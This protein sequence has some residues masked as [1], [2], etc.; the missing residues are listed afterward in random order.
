MIKHAKDNKVFFYVFLVFVLFLAFKVVLAYLSITVLAFIFGIV[1]QSMFKFFLRIFKNKKAL[2]SSATLLTFLI[3]FFIPLA[4]IVSITVKQSITFYNDLND[5]IEGGELDLDGITP[6][7]NNALDKIPFVDIELSEAKVLSL[8]KENLQPVVNFLI[9]NAT[10][11]GT[12]LFGSIPKFIIFV[13]MLSFLIPNQK[14]LVKQI[15]RLSPLDDEID[16]LL[17]NKFI[18]MSKSMI[19]GSF[20]IALVQGVVS[21]LMLAVVGVPYSIFWTLIITFVSIIPLGA[22]IINF[23]IGVILILFGNV[24]QGILVLVNH[25]LVITNLDNLLRPA[26]VS[27]DAHLHPALTLLGALGG[28]SAFGFWGVIYGPVI[29]II[30]VTTLEVYLKYYKDEKK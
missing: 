29:M 26:L 2:A 28:I 7:L 12:T 23:P 1:L 30:L 6:K 27:K 14:N 19:K 3:L 25:F 4:F 16:N 24:W 18:S 17:I 10:T 11:V 15:K 22:G 13:M 5:F 8:L 20:V 21:G 9:K